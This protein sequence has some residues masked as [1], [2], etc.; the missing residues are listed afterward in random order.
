VFYPVP[1]YMTTPSDCQQGMFPGPTCT[2]N[3]HEACVVHSTGCL[4]G[5]TG[6]AAQQLTSFLGCYVHGE[7]ADNTNATVPLEGTCL[8]GNLI[9][10]V[11]SSGV[12]AAAVQ[13]CIANK[14]IYTPIMAEALKKSQVIQTYPHCT[15]NKKVLPQED[16]TP[17]EAHLKKALCQA[18]A[19]S[20]C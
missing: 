2:C 20:A 4:G 18:G 8:P 3:I 5:C 17:A 12:P 11:A 14:K 1:D 19:K 13:K 6:A 16:P 15:V 10:C 9:K 7:H